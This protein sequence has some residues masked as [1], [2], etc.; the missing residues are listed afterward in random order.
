MTT[1]ITLTESQAKALDHLLAAVAAKTNTALHGPAGTGKTTLTGVLIKRL[2]EQGKVIALAAPT[3]KAVGVLRSKVPDGVNCCTVASLLGLKPVARGRFISFVPDFRQAERRGQLRGVDVLVADECS[4][5]SEALGSELVKLAKSTATTVICVGDAS[6]L[7]PVDPPPEPGEDEA[8]HRGVMAKAFTDPVGGVAALTEVVRHQGPVLAFATQLRQCK[9]R[10]EI[11]SCWP[12][13]DQRDDDS[14]IVV[15]AWPNAW[16]ASAKAVLLDPRWEQQPDAARILCWSNR[17]VDRITQELRTARYGDLAAEGWQ[18]NEVVQ[19]G[20]A[21][22]QPGKSMAG[23]L[24]PSTCEWRVVAAELHQLRLHLGTGKWHTPK[25]QEVR[26]FDIGCDLQ[27]QRLTLDPLVPGG[28]LQR[29]EACAPIPG[30][31]AWGERISE[32]RQQIA[33]IEAG[34]PRTKAWAQWHELK[35]YICDLRSAA[36]LTVHRSQGSTFKCVWINGDLGHCNT[37]DLVPLHY[38]AATRAS[39]Q[40][41]VLRR[42]VGK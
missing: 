33:K 18:V 42:E 16:F 6:Q 35:S 36:V 41:H 28:R 2:L 38:T 20:D 34:K 22:Q 30:D 9:T 17:A 31:P 40:L 32:L 5:L 39:Q 21:I 29:I 19:N 15:H 3:H 11:N 1:P 26:E 14:R 37:A 10:D 12:T 13:Q 24:A 25:R 7:P 8:E 27:V 4:M 23:P